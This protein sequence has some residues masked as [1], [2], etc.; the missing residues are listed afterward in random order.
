MLQKGRQTALEK[1]EDRNTLTLTHT[2]CMHAHRHTKLR[3]ICFL[4][5]RP[6]S[7]SGTS[8]PDV[9]TEDLSL[10]TLSPQL[11]VSACTWKASTGEGPCHRQEDPRVRPPARLGQSAP[12]SVRNLSQKARWPAIEDRKA[13]DSTL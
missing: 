4:R 13:R 3:F 6:Y 11:G 1:L 8:L 12:G 7:G 9:P 10:E 5:G 2:Q